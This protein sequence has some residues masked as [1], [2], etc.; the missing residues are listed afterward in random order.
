MSLKTSQMQK[1]SFIGSIALIVYSLDDRAAGGP[2]SLTLSQALW[3]EQS[4]PEA[5]LHCRM[6]EHQ[7]LAGPVGRALASVPA[8][9]DSDPELTFLYIK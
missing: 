3:L 9:V 2:S 6:P 8:G 4:Q 5:Q 1:L 7:M